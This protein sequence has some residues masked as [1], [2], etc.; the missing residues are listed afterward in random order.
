M[1]DFL[2]KPH[3]T[4]QAL[5]L[6]ALIP[7]LIESLEKY[8]NLLLQA[9]AGSGKT[10]RVPPALLQRMK[11][12]SKKQIWVLEPRRLAA[13]W[14][15]RRV[16]QELGE[17]IG[18]RVGYQ[19][20]F[21]KI[22]GPKT[23]LLFL[24]EGMFSRKLLSD[25]ELNSVD[26]V[27]LDEFH[28]RHLQ[29]DFA[30]SYLRWLQKKKR[31][32][33]KILVMSAT[34]ESEKLSEFLG[35]APLLQLDLS[36]FPVELEYLKNPPDLLE[37]EVSRAL[38]RAWSQKPLGD[39]LI[40]LP[41]IREIRRCKEILSDFS[42]RQNA[43]LLQLHGE[44]PREEQDR[45]LMPARQRKII[46]STNVA[47]S[48]LTIEGV[49]GV[50]DTGLHR[51]ASYS[52]W[53]GIPSLKTKAICKASAIQRAG[54]AGRLGPGKCIRLYTRGDFELRPPFEVPEIQRSDL[55][56]L[57]LELKSIPSLALDEFQWFESP[58]EA[59][60][61]SALNLLFRLG[62]ISGN[63]LNS[64]ITPI[65]RQILRF[66]THPRIGR[67]MVEGERCLS[68]DLGRAL[69]LLAAALS[70]GEL[71]SYESR[72]LP[73]VQKLRDQLLNS[74][75]FQDTQDQ[76]HEVFSKAAQN[77]ILSEEKLWKCVLTGF[78]DRV[79]RARCAQSEYEILMSE[80]GSIRLRQDARS[81][82]MIQSSEYLLVLEAQETKQFRQSRS[83]LWAHHI[84]PICP[85]WLLDVEPSPLIE[86]QELSWEERGRK[87]V[88]TN[89]L[90]YGS[91]VLDETKKDWVPPESWTEKNERETVF[92]LFVQNVLRIAPEKLATINEPEWPK[93]LAPLWE[94]DQVLSLLSRLKLLN[95]FQP[96]P[97]SAR[98]AE[99]QSTYEKIKNGFVRCSREEEIKQI[100]LLDLLLPDSIL[101]QQLEQVLPTTLALPGRK[102]T[103]IHYSLDQPP[104]VESRLQDFFGLTSTP[105]L[106]QGR[107]QLTLHL[108]APNYRAVQ[109]TTD[110]AGFWK[111]HYPQLRR[112]LCRRYPKHAW[113]EF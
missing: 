112:E 68:K 109:V 67:V 27:I 76:K 38:H 41:G 80:G 106:M 46:L 26:I 86:T 58:R 59:L 33:L 78:P 13:K 72:P 37:K 19:F 107:I 77:K 97:D 96:H 18:L 15:A 93:I 36:L 57:I 17:E 104:W 9:S 65:G 50:I 42:R 34:L 45:V 85:E 62:A 70:E 90:L 29:G 48:S 1:N 47:E 91:L 100:N 73:T 2:K 92:R 49:S 21:E 108:L 84:H 113:P 105:T 69:A 30:L 28:E 53:S 35:G 87:I 25:P 14:A 110:L 43:L 7:S 22:A 8:P 98:M 64:P 99:K 88:Y 52:W 111:N 24:T 12:E 95:T 20:R 71:D 6:D 82:S 94:E 79:G 10:T 83:E 54:R 39:W 102:R 5:P 66:S 63:K 103:P 89:Q 56:Q 31:P 55:S 44:L 74:A 75:A 23:R 51:Q 60:I 101:Q 3:S 61:H 16:A 40:F 32:D 4:L 81:E 11:S